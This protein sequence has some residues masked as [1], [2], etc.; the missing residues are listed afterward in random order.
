LDAFIVTVHVPVPKHPPPDQP[1][2]VDPKTADAVRVT[3]SPL[4]NVSAQSKPQLMP[5]GVLVTEPNPVPALLT[6]RLNRNRNSAAT[7]RSSFM[8]ITQPPVPEQPL[9]HPAKIEPVAAVAETVTD[10]PWRNVL[11]HAAPQLIPDGRVTNVPSPSPTFSTDRRGSIRAEVDDVAVAP[12]S[13]VTL[14]TTV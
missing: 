14:S 3:V 2:N 7:V 9:V 1:V 4:T 6:V 12:S 5:A 11:E 8:E 13:S 10:D